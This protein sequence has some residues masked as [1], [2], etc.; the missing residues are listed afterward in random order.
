MGIGHTVRH[1]Q[2]PADHGIETGHGQKKV[3]PLTTGT[4]TNSAERRH[5]RWESG[6]PTGRLLWF[7]VD[8]VRPAVVADVRLPLDGSDD[9]HLPLAPWTP[10]CGHLLCFE[11][12]VTGLSTEYSIL[13]SIKLVPTNGGVEADMARPTTAS[14]GGETRQYSASAISSSRV[15]NCSR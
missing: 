11:R 7:L 12:S 9:F 5:R 10:T 2:Y 8:D 6:L 4:D 15:S 14:G 3:Y 1:P 13:D